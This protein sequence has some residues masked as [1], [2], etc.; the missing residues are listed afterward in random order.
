MKA[1]CIITLLLPVV[2]SY[3][4]NLNPLSNEFINYINSKQN[5]WVAGKNFD[6]KLSI[7][8][9]KNL[10]GAKKRSLGDVKGFMHSEDIQVPDSFDARENWKDCSDV[11]STIVDQ[12]ACGSCWAMS[13]A[14][15]MSDRRCIVTQGKLKVPVS[16]ENLLSCC[17]DCGFG[18]AGG[19]ID[20]AWSFWQENGITT[21]GLYGSNQ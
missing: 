12:S 1:A 3:K 16:A 6:E 2:L 13:A 18:C 5:T 9:I 11:I 4:A 7:Q 20:D 17:D 15:A 10:L 21:G 14:S 19:Y 8:E